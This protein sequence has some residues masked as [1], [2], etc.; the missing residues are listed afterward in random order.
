MNLC[1]AAVPPV[2]MGSISGS[3]TILSVPDVGGISLCFVNELLLDG[4]LLKEDN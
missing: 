2:N 3:F 1:I 4:F